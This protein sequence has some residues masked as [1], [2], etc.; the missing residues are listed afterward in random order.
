MISLYFGSPGAGKSTLAARLVFKNQKK[1]IYDKVY[2]NFECKGAYQIHSSDFATFTPAPNSLVI[3]DESGIEFNNRRF[4]DLKQ[5]V[6]EFF[7]LHR[8]YGVD[9][10][11]LSQSW[12]DTDITIRRLANCLIYIRKVGPFTMCR[13][14]KKFVFVDK[15][16]HQICEGFEF[17]KPW[18]L[19]LPFFFESP[20]FIFLRSPYY[21]MFDSYSRPE[22]SQIPRG[23]WS[24][25]ELPQH[26]Y[27]RRLSL[28]AQRVTDKLRSSKSKNSE[29]KENDIQR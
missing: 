25:E 13:K 6:I 3:I 24:S 5:S 17:H 20:L 11:F 27:G 18:H 10:V 8:H 2:T 9:I 4:K 29:E 7:K 1:Q 28:A 22:R 19:L 21:F 12:E 16:T 23:K 15:E 26:V 14:V